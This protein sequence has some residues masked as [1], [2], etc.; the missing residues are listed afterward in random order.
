MK[1]HAL[2]S[3]KDKSKY[4]KWRLLQF[5]FGALRVNLLSGESVFCLGFSAT[6]E[7][8]MYLRCLQCMLVCNTVDSRYLEVEGP[9][10]TL[11]DT[12]TSTYQIRRNEE[13]T[14]RTAKFHK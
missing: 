14:N 7:L 10:E 4:K 11:R 2:F 9:S 5:L 13:N 8:R 6:S 3:S 1:N 12:L